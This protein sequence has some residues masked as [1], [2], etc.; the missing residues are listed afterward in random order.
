MVYKEQIKKLNERL[1]KFA[2]ADKIIG[3]TNQISDNQRQKQLLHDRA[4][5]LEAIIKKNGSV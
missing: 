3:M 1:E 2:N 5:A 4:K